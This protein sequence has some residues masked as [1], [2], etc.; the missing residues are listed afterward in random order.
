MRIHFVISGDIHKLTGGSIYNER[1]MSGLKLCG[2]DVKVHHLNDDFPFPSD[3]SLEYCRKDL[4]AIKTGEPVIID[5]L[6]FGVIPDVL[7]KLSQAN[8]VIALIHLLLSSNSDFTAYEFMLVK[9]SEREALKFAAKIIATSS[10]T[11]MELLNLGMDKDKI[12]IIIPGVDIYPQK[13]SFNETPG[14]LVCISNY[15]PGK[16][17]IVLV[18]ALRK[19]KDKAWELHCYG[20]MDFNPGY[21]AWLNGVIQSSGLKDRF[22]LHPPLERH[23]LT[24][25]LLLAD[26]F[27]HPS[28]FETYGMAV[29]EALAHGVPVIASSGGGIRQTIPESMGRFFEPGDADGLYSLLLEQFENS[30]L[31]QKLCSKVIEYP[32]QANSWERSISLFEEILITL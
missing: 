7:K 18:H 24:D 31:Y 23:Q 3:K 5:S 1:I 2:H 13:K 9:R 10:Y 14:H 4:L 25:V 20:N 17:H 6:V 26:L 11:E 22:F 27:I 30:E 28:D 15:T 29:T 21:V 19:L 32:K 16:G 12:R 8:P